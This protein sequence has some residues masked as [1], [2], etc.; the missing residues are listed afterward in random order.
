LNKI[1]GRIKA[2]DE[3]IVVRKRE[4]LSAGADTIEKGQA[5]DDALYVLRALQSCLKFRAAA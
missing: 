1:P 3:A 5:L 2:A 4:L